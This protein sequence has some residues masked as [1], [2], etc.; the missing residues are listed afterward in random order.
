MIFIYGILAI[1][2][3]HI[4]QCMHDLDHVLG[5][6]QVNNLLLC[7]SFVQ[8]VKLITVITCTCQRFES[9]LINNTKAPE[10]KN[11]PSSQP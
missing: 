9:S 11:H 6:W 8:N 10:D 5:I 4:Y 2:Y 1:M 3:Y 7:C